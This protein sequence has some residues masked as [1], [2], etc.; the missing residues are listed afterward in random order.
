M[1][2]KDSTKKEKLSWWIHAVHIGTHAVHVGLYLLFLVQLVLLP[3]NYGK[4]VK[5]NE[6]LQ[7]NLIISNDKTILEKKWLLRRRGSLV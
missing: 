6:F 3:I 1:N 2:F 5:S 4:M 7:V